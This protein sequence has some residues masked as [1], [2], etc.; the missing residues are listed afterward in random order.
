MTNVAHRAIALLAIVTTSAY[1]QINPIDAC[2][3]HIAAAEKSLRLG[4]AREIRRWLDGAPPPMRAWEWH[5]LD[6]ASDT[7]TDVIERPHA[8]SRITISPDRKLLATV[9]G[10]AVHILSTSTFAEQ[11][12]IDG[13]TDA[14]YRAE[15][16][17]DSSRLV[18]VS[19]DVT[20]RVWDLANGDEIARIDL[21]NEA[22]AAAAFSPDA[23]AVAT[24][25]W[26]WTDDRKVR[27]VVW[28]WDAA[29]GDIRAKTE[30]GIKPLS[31]IRFTPDAERIV[32]GSWDGLVHVI[33]PEGLEL[34]TFTI[35]EEGRYRAV[36]DVA[37]SADAAFVAVASKDTSVRIFSLETYDA[38]ATLR[39][40]TD[41]VESVTFS[42]DGRTLLSTS[43]DATIRTWEVD[44]WEPMDTMRGHV[45]TVRGAV[46]TSPNTIF[47]C[48]LDS[49]LRSWEC[50]ARDPSI[51]RFTTGEDGTYTSTFTPDADL[52]AVACYD[53][54][55]LLID[56]HTREERTRWAAHPGSTVNTLAMSADAT[57][58]LTCSWDK[59]AALW[60]LSNQQRLQLFD[61]GAGVY[62][63][64]I[65]P[66]ASLVALGVGAKAQIW[67]AATGERLHEI[68]V[69][70]AT[71]REI[72]FSPDSTL[73]GAAL[74]DGSI[75]VWN[76]RTAE[77]VATLTGHT[78]GASTLDFTPDSRNVISGAED[79]TVRAWD[80][81][82]GKSLWTTEGVSTYVAR[83]RV[84][85]DAS[86]IAVGGTDLTILDAATG[87]MVLKREPHIDTIWHLDWSADAHRLATCCTNGAIAILD[88]SSPAPAGEVSPSPRR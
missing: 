25:A 15:F 29:T 39:A 8:P 11:T 57:R 9:E 67:N 41:D 31:S 84:S 17:P 19:R 50:P 16:S 61:A 59:T 18:T 27:G 58:L 52:V 48:S 40:H 51:T 20:S 77:P 45:D 55:V 83:V 44:T 75:R 86:R 82:S 36:N 88:A 6:R 2:A 46:W 64:D 49:T 76:A 30:L 37:V 34:H 21:D 26:H 5:Y 54:Y 24:C 74:E 23:A 87:R 80:L 1:A 12:V 81:G 33:D 60:D 56:T 38:V 65:S 85:P 14:V 32:V 73:V 62:G 69:D 10:N 3:A 71:I 35:P 68:G 13:H 78:S 22:F 42:P 66:D 79:R 7:S 43:E 63:C 28:I 70:K 4:Q 72:R 47:S 53:G